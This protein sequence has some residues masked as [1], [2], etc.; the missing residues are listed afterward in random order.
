MNVLKIN[1]NGK[2]I[3]KKSVSDPY[4]LQDNEYEFDGIAKLG[5]NYNPDTGIITPFS[6]TSKLV[7]MGELGELL[8]DE[9][10][11]ELTDYS[12]DK[13][14]GQ[15]IRNGATRVLTR[16]NSNQTVDVLEPGFINL[17]QG[18]V[19]FTSL[20]IEQATTIFNMLKS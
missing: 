14:A 16:I 10:L 13:T 6:E 7:G 12:N 19:A 11:V 9:V 2:I 4:A 15:T 3:E 1:E 20:T 18:L 17:L 5:D 8:P